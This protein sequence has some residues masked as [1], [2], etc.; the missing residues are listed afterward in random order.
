MRTSIVT[1]AFLAALTLLAPTAS[2]AE[3]YPW[4]AQYGEWG[5]GGRNCGFLTY[6]QCMDAAAEEDGAARLTSDR[7]R[8]NY[9]PATQALARLPKRGMNARCNGQ[10][11]PL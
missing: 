2:H 4:C 5:G 3:Q 7:L 10:A 1:L 9:F 6:E 11:A 8:T